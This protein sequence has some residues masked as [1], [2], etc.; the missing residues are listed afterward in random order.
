MSGS[1]EYAPMN[2]S[3][4]EPTDAPCP[5]AFALIEAFLRETNLPNIN[6]KLDGLRRAFSKR[7]LLSLDGESICRDG[8]AIDLSEL[9]NGYWL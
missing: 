4:D 2:P 7:Q 5:T 8:I 3:G 9:E 6:R 1:I